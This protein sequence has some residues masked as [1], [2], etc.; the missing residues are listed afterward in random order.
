MYPIRLVTAIIFLAHAFSSHAEPQLFAK[1]RTLSPL[2]KGAVG[3]GVGAAAMGT[4]YFATSQ[5]GKKARAK[6]ADAAQT[7]TYV[8]R[9]DMFRVAF[10]TGW[11]YW[12]T[13]VFARLI[14][15]VTDPEKVARYVAAFVGTL[16]LSAALNRARQARAL[17]EPKPPVPGQVPQPTQLTDI[18]GASRYPAL[19]TILKSIHHVQRSKSGKLPSVLFYGALGNAE[20][21][22][23][24]FMATQAGIAWLEPIDASE[25]RSAVVGWTEGNIRAGF[26]KALQTAELHPQKTGILF[27]K[28]FHII[29]RR[30]S[31]DPM[32]GHDAYFRFVEAFEAEMKQLDKRAQDGSVPRIMIFASTH[33]ESLLDPRVK[34]TF[35]HMIKL[36]SPDDATR[37]QLFDTMLTHQQAYE[38]HAHEKERAA[39]VQALVEQTKNRSVDE[40]RHI[41]EIALSKSTDGRLTNTLLEETVKE[42]CAKHYASAVTSTTTFDAVK[43]GLPVQLQEELSKITN[44][45]AHKRVKLNG[46]VALPKGFILHGPPGTGKTLI[47]RA[48]AGS[49][50]VPFFTMAP[51]DVLRPLLGE[52]EQAMT[53]KFAECRE[54]ACGHPQKVAVLFIDE[55]EKLG[56]ARQTGPLSSGGNSAIQTL[57]TLID[58]FDQHEGHVIVIGATNRLEHVDEALKREGRL[59]PHIEVGPPSQAACYDI[60]LHYLSSQQEG[61]HYEDDGQD[62]QKRKED[63]LHTIADQAHAR[64][65]VAARIKAIVARAA[66]HR[67]TLRDGYISERNLIIAANAVLGSN[68][69]VPEQRAE[70]KKNDEK[71]QAPQAADAAANL[72]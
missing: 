38:H 18:P 33:E 63:T 3:F 48:I 60:L 35:S 25:W 71:T 9:G 51:S 36:L 66:N 27:I 30:L 58:G 40:L 42:L 17:V 52:T 59:H 6:I 68:I 26:K 47:A 11:S 41:V 50:G 16:G 10:S 56:S 55:V 31:G 39:M 64:G 13:R 43:G 44:A 65:A 2:Q 45:E 14:P 15:S 12:A 53:R 49:L 62:K 72:V 67:D 23:A 57:L 54:A 24:K 32:G 4:Y 46:K 61:Y 1:M 69:T 20:E 70:R 34:V 21:E 37:T 19:E 22:M 7:V 28:N 8:S 5:R 29:G